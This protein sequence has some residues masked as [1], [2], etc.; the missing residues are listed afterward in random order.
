MPP[1][2]FFTGRDISAN[3]TAALSAPL[4]CGPAQYTTNSASLGNSL[5]VA[6]L[7]LLWGRLTASWICPC[8]NS[9]SLRTSSYTK[10]R[11][12]FD[13]AKWVSQQSVSKRNR[14][15]KCTNA[16]SLDAAGILVTT[17]GML[18][19]LSVYNQ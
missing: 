17:D 5:K 2:N 7:I 3:L 13:I 14:L 15:L 10:S 6:S 12:L 19:L 9:S 8:E 16:S 1:I 4:Q 18:L 11:R